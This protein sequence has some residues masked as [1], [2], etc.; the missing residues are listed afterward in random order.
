[1]K[2]QDIDKSAYDQK[3]DKCLAE[4]FSIGLTVLS[5]GTLQHCNDVYYRDPFRINTQRLATLLDQF[6]KRYSPY[7]TQTLKSMVQ[8]NP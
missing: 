4:V 1:M 2:Q 7:L 3:I 6:S 5:A 8:L